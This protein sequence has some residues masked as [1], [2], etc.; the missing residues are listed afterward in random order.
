MIP[1]RL[2][3]A[4]ML[5]CVALALASVAQWA[6]AGEFNPPSFERWDSIDVIGSPSPIGRTDLAA[7]AGWGCSSIP[8]YDGAEV[9]SLVDSIELMERT[10]AGDWLARGVLFQGDHPPGDVWKYEVCSIATNGS[11]W[12]A[13]AH[14]MKWEYPGGPVLVYHG[15]R[16]T[17]AGNNG[18]ESMIAIKR[19]DHPVAAWSEEMRFPPAYWS[20]RAGVSSV[21]WTEP[22]ILWHA[23]LLWL[24]MNNQPHKE[25]RL[26]RSV[27]GADWVHVGRLLGPAQAMASGWQ[28]YGAPDLVRVGGRV[29][30]IVTPRGPLGNYDLGVV[31]EVVDLA[32]ASLAGQFHKTVDLPSDG[33]RG[34]LSF[35]AAA[36]FLAHR[37]DRDNLA[38]PLAAFEGA[39]DLP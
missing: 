11:T 37:I 6:A 21:A 15:H 14:R 19:S 22:G 4:A 1:I 29:F 7:E 32:S 34:A 24:V 26:F 13:A 36:G 16:Y 8:T 18:R 17:P 27:D 23:G 5:V 10:N 28:Y 9:S 25:V 35:E 20:A 38:R 2:L 33:E 3:L 39:G 30:L 31:F 12:F